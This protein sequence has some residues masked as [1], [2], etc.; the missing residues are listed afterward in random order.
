MFRLTKRSVEALA[1]R[2]RD[3]LLWDGDVP[4]FGV[5]V[6][7]SGKKTY[8]VQYRNGRRTRRYTI[9]SHGV[10]TAD[11]ARAEAK[12]LLGDVLRG[13]DPSATRQERR[14]APTVTALCER[15]LRDYAAIHCKPSTNRS[16]EMLI[17]LHI[18]PALGPMLINDV[19]RADVA[20]LHLKLSTDAPYQANRVLALISKLFNTAQD[21]GLRAEGSNPAHRIKKNREEEKKRYLSE[22]EQTRLGR[23]LNECLQDESETVFVISAIM[24]LMLTG[25]RRNEITTLRWDYIHYTHLDLPDSKTG[26]RRIPLPRDA[27]D[28]LMSL[29]RRD[30]N[31]YVIQG[32]TPDGYLTDLERPWRRIRERAGLEDVRLH[33]LRHTYASVAMQS[34]IDPF[35]L[36][37]IMGHR[38]LQTT[39]RYAHLADDAVQRAAGSVAARLA[40]SIGRQGGESRKLRIVT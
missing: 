21:W 10:L 15:F 29:P 32:I 4:G 6:Y 7:P 3:Y 9:G 18:R 13:E 35:T 26:R 40:A 33:D 11:Q 38:N 39:L 22:E 30:G 8:L 12:R 25:C 5:R 14:Q 17:R 36:K 28:I 2:D 37:E 16:Y 20:A 31:P 24:L 23:V 27:Y 19:T 1:I 34:G